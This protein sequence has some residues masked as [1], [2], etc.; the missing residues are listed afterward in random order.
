MI[1]RPAAG[2]AGQAV[3]PLLRARAPCTRRTTSPPEWIEP[4][5]RRVR[6]A[7]GRRGA[8]TCS[9]ASST[10]G[11]V[12][13]GT[14]AHGERPSWV[15]AWDVAR[16]ADERRLFARQM[17]VFAGL[18]LAHRRA[19]SVGS[20]R[21]LDELGVL[22]DTLVMLMSD[23]GAS[24]EGGP[25]GL[26]Q[27]APLHATRAR[28]RPSRATS[29][30]STSSAASAR[31]T[32]TRGAGRG[33]ATRRCGCGSATRGSAACARRWSCTGPRGIAGGGDGARRSSV[34]RSTSCRR[35]STPPAS[36]RADVV[37]GVD[38]AAGRRRS[39]CSPRSPT[40]RRPRRARR[41]T[42][43]CSAAASIVPRRLEGDDRPRRQASSRSSGTL[44]RGQPRLR[45]ATTGR[46]STSTHD[47][48]EAHDLAADHPERVQHLSR[49]CG[50]PR[51]SATR[52]CRSTTAS[53][54]GPSRWCRR[55]TAPRCAA[56]YRRGGGPCPR[57]PLPPLGGGLPAGG[58]RRGR[59][60]VPTG[61]SCALGDWT[62][63]W[64]LYL[65]DGVA[66]L[67][68]QPL[69]RRPDRSSPTSGIPAGS[70]ELS[71]SSTAARARR[72]PGVLAR[73]RRGGR[74]ASCR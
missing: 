7:A 35:S 70:H 33:R 30:A 18:P 28:R 67:V 62:N 8:T 26:V 31:T 20:S 48:S 65:L 66:V 54:G 47:F 38:A 53:S 58:R 50:G 12:P 17:E 25:H 24:A 41:S 21:T 10:I 32:T 64:A 15:A 57:T 9:R 44:H 23:N 16:R 71:R 68:V 55:R 52:C 36:T 46:C 6:R 11:V 34:T 4:L 61:S 42:S 45:R 29:R 3:L 56:V 14:D 19:R 69:R 27:R 49:R 37:D 39:R 72:R 2:H 59:D 60:T 40:R 13:A 1:Q 63:G 43:R 73:R 74:R 5:P 22:D 51:P